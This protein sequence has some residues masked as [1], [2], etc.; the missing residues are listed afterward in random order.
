MP[1]S[2]KKS[3]VAP[4]KTKAAEDA[5]SVLPEVPSRNQKQII[6]EETD[7]CSEAEEIGPPRLR[8]NYMPVDQQSTLELGYMVFDLGLPENQLE[9]MAVYPIN[10]GLK[11]PLP[12]AFDFSLHL[13]T[14]NKGNDFAYFAI[15]CRSSTMIT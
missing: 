4:Q 3:K 2:N 13:Y 15:S 14:G 9:E 5:P 7:T 10:L 1:D 11:L 8:E 6:S 12:H